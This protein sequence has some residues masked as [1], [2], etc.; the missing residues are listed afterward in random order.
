[1][2]LIIPLKFCMTASEKMFMQNFGGIN[3][4][5]YG[6]CDNDECGRA[7]TIQKRNVWTQIF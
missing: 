2:H 6:L 5:H 3:K 4:V 1:M 7:K